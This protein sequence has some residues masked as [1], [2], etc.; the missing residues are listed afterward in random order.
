MQED[1][2]KVSRDSV[3][4]YADL[5]SD[6]AALLTRTVKHVLPRVSTWQDKDGTYPLHFKDIM[7]L[8]NRKLL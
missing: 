8:C 6:S 5:G 1:G 3:L 4:A 2:F 7:Y